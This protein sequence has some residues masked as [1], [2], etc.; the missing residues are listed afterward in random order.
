MSGEKNGLELVRREKA[1]DSR[2]LRYPRFPERFNQDTRSGPKSLNRNS[3]TPRKAKVFELTEWLNPG[4]LPACRTSGYVDLVLCR[5][6]R[7]EVDL[8]LDFPSLLAVEPFALVVDV[9]PCADDQ[10]LAFL[11][12]TPVGFSRDVAFLADCRCSQFLEKE[13]QCIQVFI[14]D[15][16]SV[17]YTHL[18]L[19]TS[20][21][22]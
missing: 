15:L 16:A 21:L 4:R 7:Q 17:S 22:V 1:A 10:T 19:P 20:D 9:L 2:G 6:V 3:Q 13:I 8:V 11:I 12:E 14:L 18:T 5:F